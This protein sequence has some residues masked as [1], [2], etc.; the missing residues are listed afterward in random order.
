MNP[1]RRNLP[2]RSSW[3]SLPLLAILPL[4]PAI[5][6]AEDIRIGVSFAE[7]PE[8]LLEPAEAAGA[9]GFEQINWNNRGRWGN[10]VTLN[11]ESGG[12]TAVSMKWDAT[13]LY[14][15]LADPSLGGNSR[16]MKGYLDSNGT[17]IAAPFDG[18]FGNSDDK[19]LVLVTDLD[20][21]M[22]QQ[23][24]TSYSVV[25]Y[26][27]GDS[28]NG[29]RAAKVWL[30]AANQN[31]LVNG[32]PALGSDLTSRV[33]IIDGSDWAANPTFTRVTGTS[34]VGNYTV[35][36][37]LTAKA[38]YLRVDE[39]G[40]NP[41]RAPINGFQIIGTDSVA[42]ADTDNDGLPDFWENNYGLDP[43]DDGTVNIDN[44]PNGD[45]DEDGRTNIEEYNGGVDSSNPRKVDTDDDGLDDGVEFNLGTNP[46]NPDTDDDG[47]PDGW[48]VSNELDPLDNGSTDVK[49]GGDGD[50]DGELLTNLEEYQAGTDPNETDT[51]NDGYN[52]YAEDLFGSWAGIDATGTNPIKPDTDGDGV[53]DG[54]EN[55]D[56]A[57][58]PGVTYGT[59]PNLSDTDGDGQ[60]D[61]W[62]FLLGTDP[63][64]ASSALST[65]TLANPSFEQPDATGTFLVQV[66]TGWTMVTPPVADDIFVENLGSVGITGGNGAQYAGIQSVGNQI[67]Q[68]TGV[69]FQPNTTYIV[70]IAGGYR[71]GY[72]TGVLE[73]GLESSNA[74]GTPVAAYPGRL[75]LGGI[76]PDSG[77]PDADNVIN[78]LRYAS[79]VSTIGSG[80]LGRVGVFVTGATPPAG[81]IVAYIRHVSG[82]RVMFDSI[83]IIALPNTLDGDSDG[84][85]DAWELAN[86]LSTQDNG[87]TLA[88]NGPNGDPDNDGSTNAQELAAGTN[89]R[90]ATSLPGGESTAAPKVIASGFNGTAFEVSVESLAAA[91]TYTLARS[92]DLLTFTP[93]GNPVTGVTTFTFS[94]PAPTAGKGFYVIGEV[95]TP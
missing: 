70:D 4:I 91:K 2:N 51:D 84:L 76:L 35:F 78:R 16:L 94:D 67:Y 75:D 39:A 24:L 72:A 37:G 85:P 68:D 31:S 61:R 69:P 42:V 77:N 74:P 17:I 82:F 57:Y 88:I 33:D 66:P 14:Q 79:A 56:E 81:N 45:P 44:G 48:E 53:I 64:D 46:A 12:S 5:A 23:G 62:E 49:N 38:F 7:A 3:K 93:V 28:S 19:P 25:V 83:S 89:P 80:A 36:S 90:D 10:P 54:L 30:A 21:W 86:N 73:F 11:D 95:T 50:P 40:T 22:T 13:A 65:V 58:V 71:S 32:D 15:S 6:D 47:L 1:F 92:T 59:D 18:V 8:Y 55:P 26:S 60:N 27:E 63:T 9:P 87:S 34:G 41:F 43:A 52:D 20:F 29:E